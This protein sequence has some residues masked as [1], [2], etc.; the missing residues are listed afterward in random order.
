MYKRIITGLG[1]SVLLA[2]C[3]FHLQSSS[4]VPTTLKT[5]HLTSAAP[6]DP[7]ITLL[8]DNLVR[9]N[10]KLV[11]AASEAPLTLDVTHI[12]LSTDQTSLSTSQQTRQ[13]SVTYSVNLQ[14]D[15]P[16]GKKVA[17]PYSL[18]NH[19][20]LTMFSGQLIN[21]TNQ[22]AVT[23]RQL[24]RETINQLF[25]LL[26]SEN[27]QKAIKQYQAKQKPSSP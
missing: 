10:V 27:V 5:L 16:Q 24:Q 2:G 25:Y 12:G 7:F 11:N 6:Y 1:V 21:N 13:Y 3:G 9:R 20:T 4:G 22:L 23:K 26:N 15:S 17:G 14:L 19:Q 18:S 8:R